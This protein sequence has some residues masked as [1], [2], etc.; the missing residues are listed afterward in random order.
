M[1]TISVVQWLSACGVYED[2]QGTYKGA[3]TYPRYTG[4]WSLPH[5]TWG[6]CWRAP[7]SACVHGP[8]PLQ[9]EQVAGLGRDSLGQGCYSVP[10]VDAVLL[11]YPTCLFSY[12][13]PS[14]LAAAP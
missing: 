5:S 3:G 11:A 2:T 9:W 8:N 10:Q 13:L 6:F 7:A 4:S 14:S 12:P 1:S